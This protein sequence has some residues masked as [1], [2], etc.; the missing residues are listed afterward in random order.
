VLYASAEDGRL[1]VSKDAGNSWSLLDAQAPGWIV[2]AIGSGK[3]EELLASTDGLFASDDGGRS[4][5]P[6]S[7]DF[8]VDD[9]AASR[10]GRTIWVATGTGP[11][12]PPNGGLYRTTN[13]GKSWTSNF[14]LPGADVFAVYVDPQDPKLLLV[15]TDA[16]GISRTLDG[17]AHFLW[18]TVSPLQPGM[19]HGDLV[20]AF[21]SSLA[22]PHI[23]WAMTDGS[24]VFRGDEQGKYWSY[25]GLKGFDGAY[26]AADPALPDRLYAGET[27]LSNC[28][29]HNPHLRPRLTTTG[30]S[31]RPITSLP[32]QMQIEVAPPNGTLY[33][34]CNHTIYTSTNHGTT[35]ATHPRIP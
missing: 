11:D 23:V 21:A 9:V 26:L 2:A 5:R 19:P 13:G 33:A 22:S 12:G 1:W 34:W 15:A 7:C 6:W 3:H 35:W 4:W 16:G 31:W 14:D 32:A 8:L 24:G 10:D 30:R 25:S 27:P 29:T 20:I 17:G 28:K 18:R